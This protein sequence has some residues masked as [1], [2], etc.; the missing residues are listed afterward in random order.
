MNIRLLPPCKVS[1]KSIFQSIIKMH[2]ILTIQSGPRANYLCTHFWNAQLSYQTYP[3]SPPSPVNHD[4]HFRAGLAADRSETYLPRTLIY[5]F[6]PAFGTLAR[7]NALDTALTGDPADAE[8]WNGP[9]KT[10]QAGARVEA[11]PYA[12]A[13][14][15]GTE[16]VKPTVA[17]TKY[18]ADFA[19]T[20][21]HPRSLRPLTSPYPSTANAAATSSSSQKGGPPPQF[22]SFSHGSE[23]FSTYDADGDAM[24]TD[25]RSW[26]EEADA[27]QGI[28]FFSSTH[29]AW[30]GF[31]TKYMEQ[32]RDEYPKLSIWFYGCDGP[33]PTVGSSQ[34]A[35]AKLRLRERA[36]NAAQSLGEI[37]AL[38]SAYI[39]LGVPAR[40]PDWVQLD[41]GSEWHVGGL[42][43]AAVESAGLTGRMKADDGRRAPML[44]DWEDV[45]CDGGRRRV[46]GL[47]MG[48]GSKKNADKQKDGDSRMRNAG[49]ALLGEDEEPEDRD[50]RLDEGLDLDLSP[51]EVLGAQGKGRVLGRRQRTF[52]RVDGWRDDKYDALAARTEVERMQRNGPIIEE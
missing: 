36:R 49:N 18:F 51:L 5:D 20:F 43:A 32:L 8:L 47:K 35:Q 14:E 1:K 16:G 26:M 40:L 29:D 30:G 25:V 7:I 45:L 2:E 52:A 42:L 10:I 41:R 44:G 4:I 34:A 37:G 24:D 38:A 28:Q 13:L 46:V 31:A 15:E 39:P 12:T 23:L 6:K 11:S 33:A 48:L 19:S 22:S 17:T 27:P 21:F 50:E 9:V 3:P